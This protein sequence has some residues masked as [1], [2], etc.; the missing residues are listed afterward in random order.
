[1]NPTPIITMTVGTLLALVLNACASSG[2]HTS[3]T[4]TNT[5]YTGS[6]PD[7]LS[8]AG[9]TYS[10]P[11]GNPAQGPA[12]PA[13]VIPM[14]KGL[15]PA[16]GPAAIPRIGV[17][18]LL[19]IDIF[20]AEELAIKQRVTASGDVFLPLVGAVQVKG[21]TQEEAQQLITRRL[22]SKYL[23]NP[24]VNVF[25]EQSA[26]QSVTVAG[27]VGQPG[28]YPIKG[29]M[30]L[31]QALALAR[32]AKRTA[33]E[34]AVI[35]RRLNQDQVTA[36]LVDLEEIQDGNIGNPILIGGDIVHVARSGTTEFFDRVLGKVIFGEIPFGQ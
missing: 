33:Q 3:A 30:S 4:S 14:V 1:M 31:L 7:L 2:G 12:G 34:E 26:S 16:P 9:G 11:E 23:Q 17:G 21:L 22:A 19:Q 27:E 20:M 6:S 32:G 35:F 24:I 8:D 29:R 5:P 15:P 36:Y 13:K 28:I 25:V 10:T 18:D